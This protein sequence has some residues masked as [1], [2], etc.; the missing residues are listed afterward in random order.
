MFFVI[1]Y[2]HLK[3]HSCVYVR[4]R[5]YSC[6]SSSHV[7]APRKYG[8]QWGVGGRSLGPGALE[9]DTPGLESQLCSF[10]AEGCALV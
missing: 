2:Q 6:V 8:V 9:P 10:P 4:V 1:D 3:I 5:V 7:P